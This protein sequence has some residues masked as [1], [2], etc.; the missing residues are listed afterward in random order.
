MPHT[1]RPFYHPKVL[2]GILTLGHGKNLFVVARKGPEG[3]LKNMVENGLA[4]IP[5]EIAEKLPSLQVDGDRSIACLTAD[6]QDRYA[7]MV[8]VPLEGS[9]Q[10]RRAGLLPSRVTHPWDFLGFRRKSEA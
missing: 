5:P 7:Y 2:I 8:N 10:W 9:D 4:K 3:V 6:H 1:K